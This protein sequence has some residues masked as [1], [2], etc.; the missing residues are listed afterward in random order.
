MM[1]LHVHIALM[2]PRLAVSYYWAPDCCNEP[3]ETEYMGAYIPTSEA[4]D[5][6]RLCML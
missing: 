6:G 1:F 2:L 3:L 5:R 4:V